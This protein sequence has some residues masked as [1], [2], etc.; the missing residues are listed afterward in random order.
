MWHDSRVIANP[1]VF[2]FD[3]KGIALAVHVEGRIAAE[4]I[5]HIVLLPT[6]SGSL[7]S[8]RSLPLLWMMGFCTRIVCYHIY[9]SFIFAPDN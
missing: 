3:V 4:N 5:L 1:Q 8:S 9:Y 2:I 6:H 7:A